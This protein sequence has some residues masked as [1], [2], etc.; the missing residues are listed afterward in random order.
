MTRIFAKKRS[1]F[2]SVAIQLVL[3]LSLIG[4]ALYGLGTYPLADDPMIRL[5]M[6]ATGIGF[7]AAYAA[8]NARASDH[9]I[10]AAALVASTFGD[11]LLEGSFLRGLGAFLVSHIIYV[12]LYARNLRG[13]GE[14]GLPRVVI[15]ALVWLASGAVAYLL[16]PSLGE[17]RWPVVAYSG[18]ITL[19]ASLA[20]LSR[21]P[22]W[23]TGIGALLFLS[24]DTMIAMDRFLQVAPPFPHAI[25]VTYYGGQLLMAIGVLRAQAPT[26]VRG[27][28]RFD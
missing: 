19:M 28:Y 21:Y 1:A 16:M 23:L 6:K 22:F 7:L 14:T 3:V 27:G 10:L 17:M 15:V 2:H 25:W 11:V 20:I 18:V 5:I 26:E 13:K 8:L 9:W 24:S 12:L 4:A